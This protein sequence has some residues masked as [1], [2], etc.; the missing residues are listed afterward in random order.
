MNKIDSITRDAKILIDSV[1]DSFTTA[2]IAAARSGDITL[3]ETSLGVILKIL[4]V[5]AAEGYQKALGSFQ[6]SVKNTLKDR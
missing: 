3:N 4:D 1:K 2:V 5:T 6:T